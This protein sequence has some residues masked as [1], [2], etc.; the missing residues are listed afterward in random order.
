MPIFDHAS[1][2]TAVS[3]ALV[4]ADIPAGK[5]SV[6]AIVVTNTGVKGV[7]SVK[8][9]EVWTVESVFAV[10]HR[11]HIEGGLVVKASW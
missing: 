2:A 7:V 9:N 8:V 5:S 10:D 6:F 3:D 1:L 4:A 11:A